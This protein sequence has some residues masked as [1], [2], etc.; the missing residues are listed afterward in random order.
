MI[1][2]VATYMHTTRHIY[3]ESQIADRRQSFENGL[4][5]TTAE[6]HGQ[7]FEIALYIDEGGTYL[8]IFEP[9]RCCRSDN[10]IIAGP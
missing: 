1:S 10:N 8:N 3:E 7:G 6:I 9:C 5:S 4:I 2:V